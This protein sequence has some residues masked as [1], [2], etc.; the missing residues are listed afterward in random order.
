MEALGYHQRKGVGT[1][2]AIKATRVGSERS[3]SKRKSKRE[4]WEYDRV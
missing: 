1:T 3:T 4:V 2:L